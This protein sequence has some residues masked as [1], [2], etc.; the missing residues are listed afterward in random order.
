MLLVGVLEA[1]SQ[2]LVVMSFRRIQTENDKTV[3]IPKTDMN[4]KGCAIIRGVNAKS[5]LTFDFGDKGRAISTKREKGVIWLWI[6]VE[7]ETATISQKQSGVLKN[8]HFGM[9]LTEG[10]VY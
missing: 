9:D 8:Y 7:V 3:M 10:K 5:G 1:N 4:I 6:P 2:W